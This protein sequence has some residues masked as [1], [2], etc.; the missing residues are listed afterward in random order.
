MT[1]LA[2]RVSILGLGLIGGS[3]ALALKQAGVVGEISAWG[4]N[5]ARLDQAIQS[6]IVDSASTDMAL[7]VA[8]ADVVILATPLGTMA[9][10]LKQLKQC[11][12]EQAIITDVG[13]AK[14]QLIELAR[15]HLSEAFSRFVPGHPV[16]GAEHS[17]FE[18]AK[19]ELF[20]NRRVVLTPLSGTNAKA[21]KLVESLWTVCGAGIVKMDAKTHDDILALTSHLPHVV[22]YLL[23]DL[24]AAQDNP[25][26]KK[27][28]AGGFY[29]ITRIASSSP[30][31]WRDIFKDNKDSVIALL[32]QYQDSLEQFKQAIAENDDHHLIEV[33]QRAKSTRDGLK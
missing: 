14:S 12:P 23:V 4:R 24:L 22:A 10:V 18:A 17:G 31:M 8:E 19:A 1:Q 11:L 9:T 7:A 33:M 30:E 28:A 29:D 2:N 26:V 20:E 25:D 21:T 27:F 3:W 13:S 6:G 16:A 15:E 32:D 5:Q